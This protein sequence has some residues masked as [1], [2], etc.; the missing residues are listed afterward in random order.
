MTKHEIKAKRIAWGLTQKQ[1]S[2]AIGFKNTQA[3]QKY[4][5]GESPVTATVQL[6]FEQYE[7]TGDWR[8]FK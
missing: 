6:L 2:K 7:K 1:M 8:R 3:Y 5:Y 4:E